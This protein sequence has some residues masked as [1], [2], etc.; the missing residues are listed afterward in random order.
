MKYVPIPK[1][2]FIRKKKKRELT[3]RKAAIGVPTNSSLSKNK[4]K[5]QNVVLPPGKKQ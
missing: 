4:A 3:P 1:E 5:Q 2:F